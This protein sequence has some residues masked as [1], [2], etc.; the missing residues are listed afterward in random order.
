MNDFQSIQSGQGLLKDDYQESDSPITV[1][2][3]RRRKALGDK[4][5][6]PSKEDADAGNG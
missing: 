3:K 1:A 4:V 2:L 6:V 5:A